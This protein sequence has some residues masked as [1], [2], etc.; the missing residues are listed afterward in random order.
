MINKGAKENAI[1]VT[2]GKVLFVCFTFLQW[3]KYFF[4]FFFFFFTETEFHS[5]M[6]REYNKEI[7][8]NTQAGKPSTYSQSGTFQLT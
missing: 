7:K 3:E 5:I 4:F 1:L 8:E 2:M 6:K